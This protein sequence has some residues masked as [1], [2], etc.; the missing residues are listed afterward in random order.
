MHDIVIAE[1]QALL[2]AARNSTAPVR[3]SPDF[4]SGFLA[5]IEAALRV[6]SRLVIQQPTRERL[7]ERIE[8]LRTK[9]RGWVPNDVDLRED[10]RL[11][12]LPKPPC[13]PF[14]WGDR[15]LTLSD[16]GKRIT[17]YWRNP[18]DNTQWDPFRVSICAVNEE[19]HVLYG[20]MRFVGCYENTDPKSLED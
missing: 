6:V 11:L 20:T 5:G 14:E 13:P 12:T 7:L 2:E 18:F 1:L 8:G 17:V 9:Y 3:A 10:L 19:V 4:E 16:I 15:R